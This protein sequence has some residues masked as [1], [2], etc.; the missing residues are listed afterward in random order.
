MK[1][2]HITAW[3]NICLELSTLS[4][5]P[6]MKVGSILINPETN[7]ILA[8]GYNGGPKGGSELCG[9]VG[10]LRDQLNIKSGTEIQIGCSHSETNLITNAASDGVKTYGC[11]AIV[12]AEPCL[13]C[14]KILH[15]A[16]IKKVIVIEGQY[17][18]QEGIEYLQ[19]HKIAVEF[20]KHPKQE[21]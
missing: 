7:T 13:L 5:C 15:S 6:R 11:W 12:S 19:K 14:S 8:T 20:R 16:G 2:K 18:S 9:D 4:N 21:Q 1:E 10:C 17:K 3:L